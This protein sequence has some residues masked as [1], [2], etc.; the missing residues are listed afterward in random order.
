MIFGKNNKR[1]RGFNLIEIAIVLAVVGI[2]VGGIYVAASSVYE[3]NRKQEV[4]KQLLTIVQNMRA[5]YAGQV[6][7]G[8]FTTADAVA[9]RIIP[10]DMIATATT[11]INAYGGAVT[12]ANAGSTGFEVTFEDVSRG[13]CT[14]MLMKT[15][16]TAQIAD[17]LGV[18][19]GSV[20]I[21]A[22]I[23]TITTFCD[24]TNNDVEITFALRG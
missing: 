17:N 8:T 6:A 19:A 18:T 1:T 7:I 16:S 15:L 12:V 21:G 14:E 11:A 24:N 22:T 4:Q 10:Q 20:A 9:A 13:A 5:V 3:N 2:I 23:G